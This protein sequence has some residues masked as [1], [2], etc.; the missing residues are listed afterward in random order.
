M[1]IVIVST[2][3]TKNNPNKAMR[4]QFE[5]I[6]RDLFGLISIKMIH[7]RLLDP[8]SLLPYSPIPKREEGVALFM[9]SF[10]R[11][12]LGFFRK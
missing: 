6:P 5:S 3:Y 7:S 11:L 10:G 8:P 12:P 1:N 9:L 4:I 2:N